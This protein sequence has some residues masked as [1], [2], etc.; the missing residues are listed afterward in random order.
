MNSA[1]VDGLEMQICVLVVEDELFIGME[2]E[3][4]LNDGGFWGLRQLL[5]TRST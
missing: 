2:L 1:T 4:A 5:P 3:S